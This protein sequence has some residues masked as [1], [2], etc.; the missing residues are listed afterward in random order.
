[1]ENWGAWRV[2]SSWIMLQPA[3]EGE[4]SGAESQLLL[5]GC[6]PISVK[7]VEAVTRPQRHHWHLDEPALPGWN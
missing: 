6:A 1:M 2:S 4:A 7:L 3:G 5:L